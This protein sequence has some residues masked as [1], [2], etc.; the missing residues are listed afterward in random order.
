[1]KIKNIQEE[2]MRKLLIIAIVL[3]F[4]GSLAARDA[5]RTAYQALVN[6]Y[7][8]G[9][10]SV[11][12]YVENLIYAVKAPDRLSDDYRSLP[13]GKCGTPALV[14]AYN[15]M[16]EVSDDTAER[17]R[18]M[19]ARPWGLPET[20][21]TDHFKFHYTTSGGDA[22]TTSFVSQMATAFENS[23]DHIVALGFSTPPND[24]SGGGDS[25]YDIYIR[26]LSPGILGYCEPEA[27]VPGTGWNDATSFINMRNSYSGYGSP[28]TQLMQS[29]AVHEMFHGFQMG[30]DASESPWFMEVSSV[31]IEDDLY[32]T[33][34]DEHSFLPDFFNNPDVTITTYNGSHEYG[35]YLLATY[36][37]DEFGAGTMFDV[38]DQCKWVTVLAA[39]QGVAS[40]NGS[41]RNEVF[42][43]FYQ[44]NL[45]TGSR[46]SLGHY[47]EGAL[48]PEIHIEDVIYPSDYPVTGGG[49][50]HWPDHLA[51]NYIEFNVPSGA[52]GPFSITFD[53]QDGGVWSAQLIFPGTSSYA[54]MDIDLDSYGYGYVS[55]PD[56]IYGDYS[57][58]YMVVGQLST[59]GE[60]WTY[61]YSAVFDTV[62]PT[63]NPPRNL[64][65][66]SGVP[67]TVP[68]VWDPPVGGGTGGE[69]EIYYDDGTATGYLPSTAFG[70]TDITEYVKF[71]TTSPCT[72]LT[73]KLMAYNP[74]G[75]CGNVGI[76]VW[77][78]SGSDSPGIEE[79]SARSFLPTGGAWDEYDISGEAITFPAGDFFLGIDR[80]TD[81]ETGLM[82]DDTS[83]VNRSFVIVDDSLLYSLTYDYM[84]RAI[85]K[86][87]SRVYSLAPGGDLRPLDPFGGFS[88]AGNINAEI[89]D[90]PI[91]T[92]TPHSRPTETPTNYVVYRSTAPGGPWTVPLAYPTEESYNDV[93]V[94]DGT[95]YYYVV[96][97][98]YSGGESGPSNQASATPGGGAGDDTTDYE[99]IINADTA[100]TSLSLWYSDGWAEVLNVDRPA[101]LISLVYGI[102]TTGLGAYQPGLHHWQD[103]RIVGDLLP[104][105][106]E[107]C[108][109]SASDTGWTY[110]FYDVEDYGQYVNGE[111]VVSM[112]QVTGN[113]YIVHEN[114]AATENEF[115]YNDSLD[116]WFHPDTGI[117][118]IGAV[119]E[120]ID[121]TER[122]SIS[123]LVSLSGGTG[124]S[125]P[126]SDLS[127]SIVSVQGLGIAETTDASGAFEI[128]SLQPGNYMVTASRI[129]Y[130]P[131]TALVS[132]GSDVS[133]NFNLIPFN[134][135]VNP[136]RFLSARSFQ[137]GAVTLNWL[138]PVGSPGTNEWIADWE[139]D[140]MY[141]YRSR[142]DPGSVECHQFD[143]WAPC[144]LKNVRIAFYDSV[145]VYDNI[146]FNIWGDDGS[147][148]P[149]FGNELISPF[150]I[151]PTPYSPTSGIQFTTINLDSL[152]YALELLPGDKIHVGVE[153]LTSHPSVIQDNSIPMETPT[154]SKIYDVSTGS[155]D[156]A[157]NDFLMEAYVEYFEY[158]GRPSR[159][160]SDVAELRH[161]NKFSS[162]VPLGDTPRPR[163]MEGTTV[164][165][166]D[167]YRTD[168]ISDTTTFEM[169]ASAP[170]DSNSWVDA[171]VTNDQWYTYY[172]KTHQ[173]HGI[174]ERSSYVMAYPKTPD[175]SALVLLVDDDGSSWAGGVDESW[176][177]IQALL[178]AEIRFNGYDISTAY[179]DSPDLST[180]TDHE[181]VIWWTGI[182]SSDS[183]TLTPSDETLLENY[184]SAGGNLALFSQDY[185]WDR[186]NS[187]FG[188]SDFPAVQFGMD[189]ASQDYWNI[190]S[191]EIAALT[192]YDGGPFDGISMGISS[193]F[194]NFDL[195]PD[196][197]TADSILAY[198][199]DG[200]LSGPAIC[201]KKGVGF[202][203]IFST[204][205]LSAMIDTTAPSTK[206]DFVMG[207]LDGFFELFGPE[208]VE[209]TYEVTSG[210]NMLSLPLE[211]TDNSP[212]NVFPG[213]V[214]DVY[215]YDPATAN[216]VA[217]DSI[218]PG[219]GYF[220]LFFADT[221]ITH[222]APPVLSITEVLSRGWNQVGGTYDDSTVML[223][224]VTF[225]PDEFVTGN[226][227]GWS[228]TDY[229]TSTGFDPGAGYWVL[230]SDSCELE[231]GAGG[232]RRPAP[233]YSALDLSIKGTLLRL[234]IGEDVIGYRPPAAPFED[235]STAYL[236]E[237]GSPCLL[238]VKE[239]GDWTLRLE[240]PCEVLC[241]NSTNAVFVLHNGDKEIELTDGMTIDLNAGIY[242]I[243]ARVMP[244]DFAL[245]GAV[246]NPFNASTAIVFELPVE[247]NATLE[248]YDIS[249]R[250]VRTLVKGELSAGIYRETWNGRSDNGGTLPT[251]VYFYR[252]S[253]DAGFSQTRRMVLVK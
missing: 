219:E 117:F 97:A 209:V 98:Q 187:G 165:F 19:M 218:I 149:D 226:L 48:F 91:E 12:T 68:L 200:S 113:E 134:L 214:G 25:K 94:T 191:M 107:E 24:G 178:D 186:Y 132:V 81:G 129:W 133:Q 106:E 46:A 54:T 11:D 105:V 169:I 80:S 29:T 204:V 23:W 163:P 225:T 128:D 34:N 138:G 90:D 67:D 153:H 146:E 236:I 56:S 222:T 137:D 87:G 108:G 217:V 176:A 111:F 1:M 227:F 145:G 211:V 62:V 102:Y 248:I 120:Y 32:P 173:S 66:T 99:L 83:T 104:R 223:S 159:P 77:G 242:K 73:V 245:H 55:I 216:Y 114:E 53:G 251:G 21:D 246:P 231:F 208:N 3:A 174:S 156:N 4:V 61:A 215:T 100:A 51:S 181:A 253:T 2:K 197:L 136:P 203:T 15:L 60:D 243:T 6:D 71:T 162:M 59:S 65:A 151:S 45:F 125:P 168:D 18:P 89:L 234:G 30:Y 79:G 33:Y 119:V 185:L 75:L 247:S 95:A 175:D 180:L 182:L 126:P 148:Y 171:T 152:G 241:S 228:G 240:S 179:G 14:E 139:P 41:S 96:T 157:I 160:E 221:T 116:F 198:L 101:K 232:R 84:L 109:F 57:S 202:N 196:L 164:D 36:L 35:S 235:A 20:Y 189:S 43:E 28:A 127:G 167:I 58:F 42:T 47:D 78:E 112:K 154:P 194:G 224:E 166:Y 17:L 103:N 207:I 9:R 193:P 74:T 115:L 8:E 52:S 76:R 121:S 199:N 124:G 230:V 39:I 16:D 131:M 130:D 170:G 110:Y 220:V 183:T 82:V 233:E 40:D 5:E 63:Y 88:Y 44:W 190:S 205:P 140:T 201:G 192:G 150:N 142:L 210:W 252:L 135:P 118:Y 13:T 50:T 177:Y 22:T 249:G 92:E 31:W 229:Y 37:E 85:V 237:N 239:Y 147:G 123:G 155:W 143:I 93:S 86:V 188:P 158:A 238:S 27:N 172:I 144:T 250:K 7:S 244:K 195:W 10:I 72:L 69:E 212:G 206:E 213:H 122:Y 184:L 141:W 49:S 70:S 38:W 64:V 26:N 161:H